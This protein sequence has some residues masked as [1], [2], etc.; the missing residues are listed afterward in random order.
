MME[1]KLDINKLK[2]EQGKVLISEPFLNDAYFKR[3][4][5]LLAEHNEKG[6]FGFILNRPMDVKLN[7]AISDFPDYTNTLYFGGP[8]SKD[9]LFYL[10]TLG[11]EID[12]SI[13]IMKG[14][15]WGG[16]FETVK[17]KLQ[18]KE[19]DEENIRFFAGYSGWEAG[20]LDGE[21]KEKSW[22]V[23]NAGVNDI[24]S[25]DT[26]NLWREVLRKMGKEYA[27]LA[28]FP[29]DPTLN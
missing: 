1:I 17:A 7:D 13:E 18:N 4:V 6:S 29:E 9:Q 14:L 23:C 15:W 28:N 2:P 26:G 24:M 10:H 22:I 16:N 3:T 20:Q 27:I 12:E 21:M 25:S 5:V 19:I 8:V 11:K